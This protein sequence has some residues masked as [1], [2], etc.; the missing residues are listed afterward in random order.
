MGNNRA[1]RPA[2]F[3][4][5]LKFF[6]NE[7]NSA[8]PKWAQIVNRP[9]YKHRSKVV[10]S[11]EPPLLP[12]SFAEFPRLI[13]E[14]CRSGSPSDDSWLLREPSTVENAIE[15]PRAADQRPKG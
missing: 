4:R 6:A 7:A 1:S 9:I 8:T 13:C 3:R 11:K 10:S 12:F 5:G 15:R 14:A 2:P